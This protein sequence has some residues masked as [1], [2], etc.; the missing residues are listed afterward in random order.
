MAGTQKRGDAIRQFILENVEKHPKDI[1]TFT[2]EAQGLSRQAVNKHIQKL[3]AEGSL[4]ASG[5]TRNRQYSLKIT[6][7]K[8]FAYALEGLREDVVWRNDIAPLLSELP[9]NVRQIWQYGITEMLNNA[10]D[11]SSGQ[12]VKM[13]VTKSRMSSE[14]S[15]IDDGE[16][17][18]KKITR[19]LQLDD[20][21]HAILELAKGKLTTDPSRHSGEGIFFSSRMFDSFSIRSGAILFSHLP[22]INI[23]ET[24]VDVIAEH[25]SLQNGTMVWMSLKNSSTRTPKEIFDRFADDNYGFTKTIVPVFLAQYGDEQLISRSQAKRLLGRFDRFKMVV[26]DFKGIKSIGQAFAD[27]VF[28]VFVQAHPE[29]ILA[30]I[31]ANETVQGMISRA[32]HHE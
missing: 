18:F 6:D 9:D 19:E 26:L 2:A 5:T 15:I 7:Q 32:R 13:L 20:E 25:S 29:V 1:V 31:N 28:R 24:Y 21:H 14:V 22:M 17:I 4:E 23:D 8:S 10:I 11:H 16:G 27:E 12:E 30:E 3:V